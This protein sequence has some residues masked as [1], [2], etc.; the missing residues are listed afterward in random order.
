MS[1]QAVNWNKIDDD[2]DKEIWER[3]TANFWLD[4]KVP[5]SNDI[6]TWALLSEAEKKM[7]IKV[8]GGLTLLDTLQSNTGVPSLIADARTEHEKA[9]YANFTFMEAVHAKSYSSIFS[10]LCSSREIEEVFAWASTNK[11]LQKKAALIDNYYQGSNSAM[12]KAASVALESF[13]FYSGF[14]LP[15]YWS[16][17][18]KLTNTADL[19]R[20]IIRDEALHGYYIGYKFQQEF[21]EL[22]AMER[23]KTYAEIAKLFD[24]LYQNELGYIHEL[25]DDAGFAEDVKKFLNYNYNKAFQN[26]G[27]DAKFKGNDIA[28]N[29][30]ILSALSPTSDETHD[31]F[32]GSGSSYVV[33]KAEDTSDDDWNF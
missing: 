27:F 4:T 33:V 28:V 17:R 5:L 24:D 31:F 26:L 21:K 30:V 22:S 11:Y 18:A 32:S 14:Y 20:L 16:S 2:K 13:L 19:I 8:F 9:V 10:T 3:V 7:T 12:R 15:M 29:P 25:Y 6:Q 23:L 1:Y